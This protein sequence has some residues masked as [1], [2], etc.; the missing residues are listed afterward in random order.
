MSEQQGFGVWIT[1]LPASGKSSVAGAFVKKLRELGIAAVVLESDEM[2]AILTPEA[3]YSPEERDKFYRALASIGE[4]ITRNGI[5][6]IFDATANR[7]AYRD[8][9]RSHIAKFAEVYVRCPLEVCRQRDPK[10]IY[11]RAVADDT[12]TVPGIQALYE[13]PAK[14]EVTIDGEDPP[15]IGANAILA[16]LKKMKYL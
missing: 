10:G 3:T 4:V 16:A 2:R 9:A 5:P 13:P 7:Q 1:G 12:A 11:R 6:V 15:E 14:A 8:H